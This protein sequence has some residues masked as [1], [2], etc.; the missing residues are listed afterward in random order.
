MIQKKPT[1]DLDPGWGRFSERDHAHT[2]SLIMV[3]IQLDRIRV[4]VAPIR[5]QRRRACDLICAVRADPD[6]TFEGG[7][8]PACDHADGGCAPAIGERAWPTTRWTASRT[9]EWPMI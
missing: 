7:P 3:P 5:P 8:G 9:S 4:Q 1:P 6:R 2:R